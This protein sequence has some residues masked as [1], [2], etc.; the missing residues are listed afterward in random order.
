VQPCH[1]LPIPFHRSEKFLFISSQC[2]VGTLIL[3]CRGTVGPASPSVRAA[4]HVLAFG[5]IISCVPTSFTSARR[6]DCVV[7]VSAALLFSIWGRMPLL[8][9]ANRSGQENQT[10]PGT[11]VR[12][13]RLVPVS[14]VV[15]DKKGNPVTDLISSDFVLLDDGHPQEVRL[16]REET[17][18]QP[19]S[20][21]PALPPDTYT[22]Q[23]EQR[24]AVPP[25]VN[26]VLL[27]G[28]N[29][30]VSDQA[31]ARQQ[32]IKFLRQIRPSDRLGIYTLGHT[33]HVLQDFTSDPAVLTAALGKYTGQSDAEVVASTPT[34][35]QTG[36][37]SIDALLQDGF[38]RATNMYILDRVETT[39]DALIAIANHV[40][41]LPG[42]K[43]L[44]WVSG[45]FPF[46]VEYDNL[47][48][49]AAMI[50][51]PDSEANLSNQ[52]LLFAEDIE[53]AARALNDANVAVYPVDARGLLG[54]NLN[55]SQS[56][57]K[58]PGYGSMGSGQ[59][60][61][62][63]TGGSSRG[64]GGSGL[65]GHT[66][67]MP[68]SGGN[69]QAP[70][71]PILNPDHTTLE[72]MSAL[73]DGTGGEAFYNRNDIASSLQRAIDDSR[74]SYELGYYPADVKWDGSFH[75]IIVRIKRP[76]VIARA[77]K[78]YFALPE[79]V[80]GPDALRTVVM[81]AAVSPLEATGIGVAARVKAA[82]SS[83]GTVLS[84]MVFFDPRSIQFQVKNGHFAGMMNV[85]FV[86]LDDK[87]QV[88][89]ANQRSFPF[90][91]S[92]E[93]YAMFA[94]QQAEFAQDVTVMPSVSQVRVVVWDSASGKVGSVAIPLAKYMPVSNS[95]SH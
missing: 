11:I 71:N 85:L 68:R 67:R 57:A 19:A 29:T 84:T 33:L 25:N 17:D 78:G 63:L 64:D 6:R 77:R 5:N 75:N 7:A 28:L 73:A 12:A 37:E 1:P 38:Q 46:S 70:A 62:N 15:T 66:A 14:V 4:F 74:V 90:N 41:S 42:R 72:T 93:Q 49:I 82:A 32:A 55:T 61:S 94:K 27:D 79:P 8:H 45:S 95:P 50:N 56:Q 87:N 59:S 54:L 86:Q 3:W 89:H 35:L 24:G 2:H 9:P 58:M 69:S 76:D 22:N 20:P 51:N 18:Q 36:N 30:L 34:Q 13:T 39:V 40:A 92:S 83:G 48:D 80:I 47:Q 60:G 16:F 10:P 44:L 81:N 88:L 31:Y 52:Q 65:R 26:I 53:R 21:P 23:I 91:F 43:N